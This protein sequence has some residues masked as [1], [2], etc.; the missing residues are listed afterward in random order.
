MHFMY[1]N[2]WYDKQYIRRKFGI[3]LVIFMR[4]QNFGNHNYSPCLM[5]A[6]FSVMK[7]VVILCLASTISAGMYYPVDN[8]Y[9]VSSTFDAYFNHR[10]FLI[11]LWINEQLCNSFALELHVY[12]NVFA[13]KKTTTLKHWRR[14]YISQK[15]T[16]F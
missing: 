4:L 5:M 11:S 15:E 10:N 9:F 13:L 14:K 7:A 2:S 12:V 1:K 16:T 3:L 8:R 6:S